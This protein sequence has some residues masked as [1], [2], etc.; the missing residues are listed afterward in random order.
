MKENSNKFC[1]SKRAFKHENLILNLS[2][3]LG[4]KSDSG[5][6]SRFALGS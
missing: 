4:V 2:A 3:C 5:P 1:Y 6:G